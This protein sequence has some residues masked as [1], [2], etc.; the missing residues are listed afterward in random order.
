MWGVNLGVGTTG[1]SVEV[2]SPVTPWVQMRVGADFMPGFNFNTDVDAYYTHPL[3]G[4]Q[5]TSVDI[6]GNLKRTQGHVLFNF[7]PLRDKLG[8]FVAAGAYFGGSDLVKVDGYSPEIADFLEK[9]PGGNASIFLG[10]YPLEFTP[11]GH[12]TGSL[13]AK[14]FRPYLGIG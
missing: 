14:G 4:E 9:Y 12:V 8:L 5:D 10:D 1:I 3:D 11:D 7:Y 2:A 6:N 13:R